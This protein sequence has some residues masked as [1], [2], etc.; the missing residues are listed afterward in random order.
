MKQVFLSI[1]MWYL[2]NT[3]Q[4]LEPTAA[5][6]MEAL[7]VDD[8]SPA[9]EVTEDFF[10]SFDTKLEKI[11]QPSEVYGVQE[12]PELVGHEVFD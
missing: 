3:S 1:L 6:D 7:E 12:V 9:L 11:V 5:K 8:I 2:L 4:R 10:N